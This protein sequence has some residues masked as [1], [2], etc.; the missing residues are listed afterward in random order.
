MPK[1]QTK[2]NTFFISPKFLFKRMLPIQKLFNR[3]EF[4]EL[5]ETQLL[6]GSLKF[7]VI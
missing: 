2:I 1:K 5:F 3:H 6:Q 4:C 7:Q